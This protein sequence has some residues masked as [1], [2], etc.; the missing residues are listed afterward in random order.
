MIDTLYIEDGIADHPRTRAILNRFPAAARI[1]C[2]RYTEIFNRKAQNFRL[3]KRRPALILA[4]K[5]RHHVLPA[6]AGYGLGARHNYYF[7]H[8]LNCIYDCRYCFLQGM[9]RSAHYVVF[10]NYEAFAEAI[11]DTIR[12]HAGETVQFYSGY[13][14]DSL[15]F[16]PVTRFVEFFLPLF[17][18][19]PSAALEL[20]TKSTQIRSLLSRE[21]LDNCVVAF[22]FTPAAIAAAL[23]HRTP[24]VQR[25]IEAM[26]SL[27]ARGWRVGLRFDP[28]IYESGYEEHFRRLFHDI[29]T[30]I[31][32]DRLHSVS[33]GSFRL[34]KEYYRTVRRLYPD[35]PLF[36]S[37]LAEK[38]GTVAYAEPLRR[39]MLAFC[40]RHL[41]DY[42]DREK[43]HPCHETGR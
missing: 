34:P 38:N 43:I 18:R 25:R 4:M 23:E 32:A 5:W 36:A 31:D 24:P 15:A 2:H 28:L 3:Q 39:E 35:E 1:R 10:V 6:P 29:F 26:A 14:C 16:D 42:I 33:L 9:F 7:S 12:Q 19:H 20:R 40:R 30:R 11:E 22:S 37:P 27:Q 21:P 13:D 41:L 8:M 17:A